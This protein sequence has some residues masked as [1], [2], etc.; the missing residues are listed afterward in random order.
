VQQQK[1]RQAIER[2]NL[3][4][5][6]Q[7]NIAAPSQSLAAKIQETQAFIAWDRTRKLGVGKFFRH[8]AN[9]Y[10]SG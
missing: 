5:A 8:G 1:Q 9:L 6:E 4:R 2:F 10:V 7:Q 3:R